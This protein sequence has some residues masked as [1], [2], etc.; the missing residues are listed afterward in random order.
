MNTVSNFFLFLKKSSLNELI[1]YSHDHKYIYKL[2]SFISEYN[3]NDVQLFFKDICTYQQNGS[4]ELKVNRCY[5]D[6]FSTWWLYNRLIYENICVYSFKY[7]MLLDK[8][9]ENKTHKIEVITSDERLKFLLTHFCTFN[10]IHIVI[11]DSFFQKLNFFLATYLKIILTILSLPFLLKSNK[12]LIFTSNNFSKYGKF[13][14]RFFSLFDTLRK[15]KINYFI[16]IRTKNYPLVIFN[17]FIKRFKPVIFFDSLNEFSNLIY[18]NTKYTIPANNYLDYLSDITNFINVKSIK[19]SLKLH[20]ALLKLLTPN[21]AL[22]ADNCERSNILLVACNQISIPTIGIM[23][24]I[25]TIYYQVQ[26]FNYYSTIEHKLIKQRHYGVWSE[27]IKHYYLNKSRLYNRENIEISGKLRIN[28]IKSTKSFF[29]DKKIIKICWLIEIHVNIYE[30]VP[31]IKIILDNPEF[32]LTFKLDPT[33]PNNSR[34]YFNKLSQLLVGYEFYST[35]ITIEE[36]SL[37]YDLFIG[38]FSTAL[39]DVI[40]LYTPILLIN[41]KQWGNYFD[42]SDMDSLTVSNE[43]QLLIKIRNLN[44]NDQLK[45]KNIFA[46]DN[47]LK[48]PEWIVNKLKKYDKKNYSTISI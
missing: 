29:E 24:G 36:A 23:N 25:E 28:N 9:E 13:D 12:S 17:R 6:N 19:L 47:N 11:Y 43:D 5:T 1:I 34:D 14:Y 20:R 45:F 3:I 39:V 10:N 48:G 4:R 27:G 15:S 32:N 31:Y 42:I 44:F 2:D 35:D 46:P 8:I 7:K 40:S 16:G 21:S 30:L 37:N 33:K 22:I 38:A 41:T 26:K 18:T